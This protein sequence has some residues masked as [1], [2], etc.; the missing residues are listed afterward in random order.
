MGPAGRQFGALLWKNWLCRV[1]QPVLSLAEFFW[2]CILF[3]ILT[4]LR[5]Q[6][7]PRH[8][9]NCF[10]QARDLPSRGVLPFMQA[11]LCNTGS[12]CRNVSSPAPSEGPRSSS[13]FGATAGRREKVNDLA[14]LEEMQDLAEGI[15][16]ILD[17]AKILRELW[18]GGSKDADSSHGSSLIAMDLNKTEEVILR[19]EKLHQQPHIWDFLRL[20]PRLQA[21]DVCA[22]DYIRGGVHLLHAAS[23]SLAT[24]EDLDWLPLNHTFST[25]SENVL[26]V[27]IW[28]LTFLQ[29]HG[30]ATTEAGDSPSLQKLLWGPRMAQADLKPRFGFDEAHAEQ[31]LN[32]SAELQEVGTRDASRAVGCSPGGAWVLGRWRQVPAGVPRGLEALGRR[33]GAGALHAV[34]LVL[35]DSVAA[36][37]P[38]GNHSA[39]NT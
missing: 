28:M 35:G 23:T 16:E 3:M 8:R 19:L 37:G 22:E 11:L 20:L 32:Y 18:A 39:P 38:G 21:N 25:V 31:I 2:P 36:A 12:T 6:E 17:R 15:Y 26:N 30:V 14:F 29:E 33:Q 13:R 27:T 7:P 24:L 10:L 34:P 9:D 1:R 5:F 4:V